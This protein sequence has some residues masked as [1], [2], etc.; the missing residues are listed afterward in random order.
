VSVGDVEFVV[1]EAGRVVVVEA[2]ELFNSEVYD[3]EYLRFDLRHDIDEPQDH[4]HDDAETHEEDEQGRYVVPV[5]PL[6]P[7]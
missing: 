1:T 2:W 7:S 6:P 3:A 5:H 4:D